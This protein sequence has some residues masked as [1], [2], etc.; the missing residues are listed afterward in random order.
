MPSYA[1]IPVRAAITT[2]PTD[3]YTVPAG[4]TAMLL[5]AQVANVDGLVAADITCVVGGTTK[6]AIANTIS[7]P[8]DASIGLLTGPVPLAAGE[9]VRVTASANGDLEFVGA[10]MEITP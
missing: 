10:V 3:I 4:K 5:T 8:A 6:R 7:V 1:Y 2:T 9:T